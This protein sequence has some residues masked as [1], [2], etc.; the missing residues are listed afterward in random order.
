MNL[1][2]NRSMSKL[3]RALNITV[4][5]WSDLYRRYVTTEEDPTAFDHACYK[6]KPSQLLS[7]EGGPLAIICEYN[8]QPAIMRLVSAR[9][10]KLHNE[11][12]LHTD[13]AFIQGWPGEARDF[14][15]SELKRTLYPIP[16]QGRSVLH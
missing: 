9:W 7:D 5:A 2:F 16:I 3:F 8:S 10:S 11:F 14:R 13:I 4:S 12:V 1:L 6:E 15:L